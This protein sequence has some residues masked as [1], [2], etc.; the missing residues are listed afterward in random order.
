MNLVLDTNR[1]SDLMVGVPDVVKTLEQAS[2]IYVPFV[3][4][5]ELRAG[6]SIG[7][8][9]RANESLLQR[10]LSRADVISLFP[11]GETTRRYAEVFRFLRQAGAPIPTN[12]IWI[13]ALALQHDVPLYARDAHFDNLPML[14]RL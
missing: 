13:V 12:D 10:F 5:G 7:S 3:T 9:G 4:I 2:A 14:K 6:F 1:Y 11:D 8:K